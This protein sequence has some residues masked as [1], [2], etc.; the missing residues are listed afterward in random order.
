[1]KKLI[2]AT[3]LLAGL[4]LSTLANI[5]N[6]NSQN[7]SFAEALKICK[8]YIHVDTHGSMKATTAITGKRGD[9]C[10]LTRELPGGVEMQ[11]LHSQEYIKELEATV[12]TGKTSARFAELQGKE[13]AYYN[14]GVKVSP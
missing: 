11:C 10:H 12:K 1:M 5:S 8:P 14:N 4:S 13:C 2:F 3:V 7:L 6:A 9:L